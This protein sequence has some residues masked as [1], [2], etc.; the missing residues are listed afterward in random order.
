MNAK[1]LLLCLPILGISIAACGD[2][3]AD[4]PAGSATPAATASPASPPGNSD[5]NRVLQF[6][7]YCWDN[8]MGSPHHLGHRTIGDHL[9]TQGE[10]RRAGT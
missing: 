3:A 2:S 6:Y 5:D 7:W 4:A 9:C 10:L 1:A 8:G